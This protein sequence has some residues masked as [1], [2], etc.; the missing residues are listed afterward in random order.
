MMG[1][2]GLQFGKGHIPMRKNAIYLFVSCALL[3]LAG[4][5]LV[6]LT[7]TGLGAAAAADQQ[8]APLFAQGTPVAQ[9][10]VTSVSPTP[11][12]VTPTAAPTW[13]PRT[14]FPTRVYP[15]F[16]GAQ[17]ITPRFPS[18]DPHA[19]TFVEQDVRDMF[20]RAASRGGPTVQFVGITFATEAQLEA[21]NTPGRNQ[22]LAPDRVLCLVI[23]TAANDPSQQYYLI[24]AHTGNL[25][26]LSEPA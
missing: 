8:I 18:N 11:S 14:P 5:V 12:N 20:T 10:G 21:A 6:V 17:A 1:G 15:V 9:S 26:A 16:E 23:F 25:L 13:D 22:N 2:R 4:G 24:D 3:L 19:I 7:H